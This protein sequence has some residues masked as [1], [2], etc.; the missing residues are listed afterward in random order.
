MRAVRIFFTLIIGAGT[1]G[2]TSLAVIR[3]AQEIVIAAD[4]RVT[5]P[6]RNRMEGSTQG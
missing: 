6:V 3:T 4:S 5:S 2:A 1:A